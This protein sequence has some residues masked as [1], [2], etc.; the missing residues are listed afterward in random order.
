MTAVFGTTQIGEMA[1]RRVCRERARAS[2]REGGES[3]RERYADRHQM[4]RHAQAGSA[5][6]NTGKRGQATRK[7]RSQERARA[8]VHGARGRRWR[9]CITGGR[10][11]NIYWFG[12]SQADLFPVQN[13][14]RIYKFNKQLCTRSCSNI[15]TKFN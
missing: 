1:Q 11:T 14:I 10:R 3:E 8:G 2:V 5:G 15:Y 9:L 7:R 4:P 6:C 13:S 12:L